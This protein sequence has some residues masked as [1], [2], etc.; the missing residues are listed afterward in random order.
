[1]ITLKDFMTAVDYRVTEGSNYM[2][3]CYGPNAYRLDSWNGDQDGHSVSIVFDTRTQEVY[4]SSVYDYSNQRAYRIINPEYKD[5]HDDEALSRDVNLKEAWDDVEYV[6]LEVEEDFL[7]K[8]EAI[9]NGYDYDTR[10]K[11]PVDFT[12]EELLTYMKMAHERDMTFNEFVETALRAA[13]D[14]L[15]LRKELD[16][17]RPEYDF[18]DAERGPVEESIEKLKKKKKGK[19]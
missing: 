14:E 1:M 16:D 7:E 17:I 2:W 3:Q 19:K 15:K 6:D 8:V 4:E 5:S 18:S 9:V 12:D 13:V 11:V 10:V